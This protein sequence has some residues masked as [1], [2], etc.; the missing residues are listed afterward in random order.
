MLKLFN[1]LSRSIEEFKPINPDLVTMYA[2][3][4]TVYDYQH[5]GNFRK[6]IND[7]LVR[8]VIEVNG[9]SLKHV[10]NI[11]DVGHLVSDADE[12]E[13]KMEKGAHESGRTVW[14]VAKYFEADFLKWFDPLNIQL[15]S[16]VARATEHVEEMVKLIQKLEKNEYIYIT[17][18]AIYFDTSKFPDY[19][20]LSRQKLEDK[21]TGSRADVVVDQSKK[22]P[23]DFA[24]WFFTVGHFANHAMKWSSPWGEGFP[25]WHIEC[26]AMSMLYLGD[27][28]DIHTG[29]IDHI[30]VHH[31]NEIAQSES[32]SGQKFVNYWIHHNF[33]LVE[34]QKMSKSKKNYLLPRDIIEKGYDL[35]ALRYLYLGTHY[36]DEINITWKSLE[37]ATNAL[38]NLR[39]LIR[40]WEEQNIQEG[41][42]TG[43][44]YYQRFLDAISNDFNVPQGLAIMWEMAKSNLSGSL[45]KELLLK[46][47]RVLGLGIDKLVNQKIDLSLPEE[48]QKLVNER[49]KA[50]E[51]KDFST[52]DKLRNEIKDLG[53]DVLDTPSGQK[54][55]KG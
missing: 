25:G 5:I 52:A 1:T 7:D 53:F 4:P 30:P 45:K 23:A 49:E 37:A 39:K 15:P 13:D 40:G 3:G 33:I 32:A 29:G 27:S 47:D 28:I 14:E 38:N 24:L 41:E 2:C 17:D 35:L 36:R 34:G 12:G 44:D 10:M 31:T 48:V 9:Y 55:V 20:K 21:E 16:V 54:I 50:R 11:T 43:A 18:Q 26:S 19:T 42:E 22:N 51:V 6:Y 8:R 46:M